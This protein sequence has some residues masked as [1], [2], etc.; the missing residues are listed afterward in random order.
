MTPNVVQ[1]DELATLS[2]LHRLLTATQ[3]RFTQVGLAQTVWTT[4]VAPVAV[5]VVH[6]HIQ[7]VDLKVVVA[8]M[9]DQLVRQVPV[10]AVALLL[11]LSLAQLTM[12]LLVVL[13]VLVVTS[14]AAD[15][16]QMPMH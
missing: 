5:L 12:S 1:P 8:V 11:S 13:V 6:R 9:P 10:V 2:R 15:P 7:V 3:F 16:P 14:S 4:S